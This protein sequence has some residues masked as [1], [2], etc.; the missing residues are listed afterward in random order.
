M[1][2]ISKG[3]LRPRSRRHVAAD[4]TVSRFVTT[5][6][7]TLATRASAASFTNVLMHSSTYGTRTRNREHQAGA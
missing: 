3:A 6:G 5:L 4:A 2:A 7:L 1:N